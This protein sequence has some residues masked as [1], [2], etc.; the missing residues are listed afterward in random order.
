MAFSYDDRLA[1]VVSKDADSI[2][3]VVAALQAI[4]AMLDGLRDGLKWFNSLYLEVTL[5]VQARVAAGA[6][7]DPQGTAFIASLDPVFANFYFAA[8]RGWLA[9]REAP[10]SWR[11]LFKERSNAGL[12]RIQFALAGVNAHINRDLMVAITVTSKKA[13]V[14]PTHVT[15]QYRAFTALNETLDALIE[16]AKR[17]LMVTLPGDS[18]PGANRV[19]MIVAAWSVAA[20]REAAWVHSEVLSTISGQPLL[21]ERFI[22]ALDGTA[23]LAGKA[24]LIPFA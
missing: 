20:A 8:L 14:A 4:D 23:E 12:G 22:D 7:A 15:A 5:A 11:V 16:R 17:E 1:A 19:E 18:L 10:G 3:E 24:L 21:A 13:G 6:F 9:G 2:A